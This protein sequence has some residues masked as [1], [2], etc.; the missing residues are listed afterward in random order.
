MRWLIERA[1]LTHDCSA[2]NTG[3][4]VSELTAGTYTAKVKYL[5]QTD[6]DLNT[7]HNELG[8]QNLVVVVL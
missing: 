1:P 7:N 6:V 2:T 3:L 5:A 8:T 4:H